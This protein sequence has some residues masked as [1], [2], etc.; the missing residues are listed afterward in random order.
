MITEKIQHPLDS[1]HRM[2]K[3]NSYIINKYGFHCTREEYRARW[4]KEFRC[5]LSSG[6]SFTYL[7]FKRDKDYMMY[8]LRFS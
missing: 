8:C 2:Y 4:F 3:A 1:W 7:T 5:T 6:D